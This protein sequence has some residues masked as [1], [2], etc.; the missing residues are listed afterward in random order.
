MPMLPKCPLRSTSSPMFVF[1]TRWGRLRQ[2][3]NGADCFETA[4]F[5]NFFAALGPPSRLS[6]KNQLGTDR[7]SLAHSYGAF[8]S[9]EVRK[10]PGWGVNS[11][12]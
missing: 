5:P 11:G 1:P 4:S 9:S 7:R 2:S 6:E 8:G 12:G 3:N 10:S